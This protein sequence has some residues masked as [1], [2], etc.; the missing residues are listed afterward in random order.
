MHALS[1]PVCV[2]TAEDENSLLTNVTRPWI[3]YDD[4]QP[5]SLWNKYP[6][7]SW[8]A[9]MFLIVFVEIGSLWFAL[10]ESWNPK[11]SNEKALTKYLKEIKQSLCFL[12]LKIKVQKY[13]SN[14]LQH[15]TKESMFHIRVKENSYLIHIDSLSFPL[16]E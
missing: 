12:V 10:I 1:W 4:S 6:V 16:K 2:G 8:N 7:L 13:R 9:T 15:S 11:G 3:R 14:M 5:R